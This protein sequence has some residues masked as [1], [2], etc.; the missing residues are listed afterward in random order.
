MT[1]GFLNLLELSHASDSS[2][3]AGRFSQKVTALKTLVEYQVE[4]GHVS[5]RGRTAYLGLHPPGRY[6][7]EAFI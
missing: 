7:P 1:N 5:A 3:E 6:L 2:D 4:G